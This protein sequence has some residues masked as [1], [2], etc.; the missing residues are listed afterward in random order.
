MCIPVEVS[1]HLNDTKLM[2]FMNSDEQLY[3]ALISYVD[4][5]RI[6]RKK[7]RRK[8]L[9]KKQDTQKKTVAL[10]ESSLIAD[11]F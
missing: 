10:N 9:N 7:K 5:G 3:L 11:Y 6:K 4:C 2:A 8:Y 1:I